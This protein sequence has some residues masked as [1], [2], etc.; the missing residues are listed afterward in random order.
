MKSQALR[1]NANQ[2]LLVNVK[3][4]PDNIFKEAEIFKTP[5]F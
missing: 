4:K 2:K 5:L 3:F 1:E